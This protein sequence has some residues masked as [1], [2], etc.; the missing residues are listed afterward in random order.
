L[1]PRR[2]ALL[3]AKFQECFAVN[4]FDQLT[5]KQAQVYD[6]IRDKIKNRGYGPTV[7]EIGE[8]FGIS[9]PNGVMCHLKALEKKGLIRARRGAVAILNRAG[10]RKISNGAYGATEAEFQRLF[11]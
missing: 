10:L 6:F 1:L 4:E 9:S 5:K 2:E 7:R 11:G 8:N 3:D